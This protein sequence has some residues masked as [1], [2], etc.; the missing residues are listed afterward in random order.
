MNESGFIRAVNKKLPNDI[1]VWKVSDR[2]SAGVPDTYYSSPK[3][4][5]W[6]E[7]KFLKSLTRTVKPHLS[8]LQQQW[9]NNRYD[10]GRKV[11][12]VVGSPTDCLI[13]QDKEWMQSKPKTQSISRNELIEWLTTQLT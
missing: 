11:F 1:Y 3:G 10:E 4:D 9:L 6:V 7:W 12:V 5:L 8:K 2:F 13:Y